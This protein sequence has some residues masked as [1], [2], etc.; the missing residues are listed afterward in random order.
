MLVKESVKTPLTILITGLCFGS[1]GYFLNGVSSSPQT[2]EV[3][4]DEEG[5][6][7][8]A[9]RVSR[10]AKKGSEGTIAGVVSSFDRAGTRSLLKSSMDVFKLDAKQVEELLKQPEL[11][12]VSYYDRGKVQVFQACFARLAEIDPDR[13]ISFAEGFDKERKY[14]A[15]N[16]IFQEW[17]SRDAE[18]A[19][20]K[21][22]SLEPEL[23]RAALHSSLLALSKEDP[24]KAFAIAQEHKVSGSLYS[25]LDQWAEMDPAMAIKK[26]EELSGSNKSWIKGRVFEKWAKKD[27]EA[28]NSYVEAIENKSKRMSAMSGLITG[29][30]PGDIDKAFGLLDQNQE[31]VDSDSF[32]SVIGEL[33]EE[34]PER[35]MQWIEDFADG[36]KKEGLVSSVM[37]RWFLLDEKGALAYYGGLA[38]GKAKEGVGKGILQNLSYNDPKKYLE[39]YETMG[40]KRDDDWSYQSAISKLAVEDLDFAKSYLDGVSDP[41]LKK[42]VFKSILSGLSNQDPKVAIEMAS[43]VKDPSDRDAALAEVYQSIQSKNPLLVVEAFQERGMKA[44]GEYEVDDFVWSYARED[45]EGAKAFVEQIQDPTLWN[46]SVSKLL[47]QWASKDPEEAAL[48]A[49]AQDPTKGIESSMWSIGTELAKKD[50]DE[51]IR[52]ALSQPQNSVSDK[53]L[54]T[55]LK[56]LVNE[57]LEQAL[58]TAKGVPV[59]RIEVGFYDDVGSEYAVKDP[60]EGIRWLNTIVDEKSKNSATAEFVDKLVDKDADAAAHYVNSL[61]EGD[62]RDESVRKMVYNFDD[63]EPEYALEWAETISNKGSRESAL[64]RTYHSWKELDPQRADAWLQSTSSVNQKTKNKWSK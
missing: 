45:L 35:A 36:D 43:D 27:F 15:A 39:L 60:Q 13:A 14:L 50:P 7:P 18:G 53:M 34:A 33:G 20:S 51:G 17:S 25:I 23:K 47:S 64:R 61:P 63:A 58:A 8:S 62:R 6:M 37:S 11:E 9:M 48:F 28:A 3:S 55:V 22:L 26:S 56:T 32:Y 24:E 41:K 2:K 30:I 16:A 5:R 19:L 29:L 49:F 54:N 10:P 46:D 57:D 59:G 38:A 40:S 42:Q 12:F 31:L 21:A 1:F 44:I 52:I 4:V